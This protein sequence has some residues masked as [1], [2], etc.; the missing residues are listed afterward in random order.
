MPE[1]NAEGWSIRLKFIG[2]LTR[3]EATFLVPQAR[4]WLGTHFWL[5]EDKTVAE[6]LVVSPSFRPML[7]S[8]PMTQPATP[9][10]SYEQYCAIE[11][12]QP[13]TV[14]HEFHDGVIYAMAGG[15]EDHS[16]LQSAWLQMANN[17]LEDRLDCVAHGSDLRIYI[18]AEHTAVFPD[19]SIICGALE[20][21]HASPVSTALNPVVLLE[22][23]SESSADYDRETK[24]DWYRQIPS[25]RCYCI[26]S[27]ETPS[28]RVHQRGPTGWVTREYGAKETVTLEPLSLIFEVGHLYR[29]TSL[30]GLRSL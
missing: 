2:S 28:I 10:L 19:A 22:V 20:Q 9:R 14:R 25:L 18:E 6:V 8:R 30:A 11:T 15:T 26:M 16:K 12:T 5:V 1:I 29:R 3:A 4:K 27:H 7:R 24:A 21:H 23:T 17:A 13:Y